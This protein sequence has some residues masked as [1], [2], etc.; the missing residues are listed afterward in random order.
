M[1]DKPFAFVPPLAVTRVIGTYQFEDGSF[2]SICAGG[3]TSTADLMDMAEKIIATKRQEI[4]AASTPNE[5][6]TA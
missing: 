1:G 2:V 4:A 6:D 5:G 3:Q